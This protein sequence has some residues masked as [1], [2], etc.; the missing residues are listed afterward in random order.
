MSARLFLFLILANFSTS[1]AIRKSD[2]V[3]EFCANI[4]KAKQASNYG[5]FNKSYQWLL[6]DSENI[7][8]INFKNAT[9]GIGLNAQVTYGNTSSVEMFSLYDLHSKG[10][11]LKAPLIANE[12]ARWSENKG[13]AVDF[14]MEFVQGVQN[15]RNFHGQNLRG[16]VVIDRDDIEPTQAND[17]LSTP[18][19][20]VGVTAFSKYH[21]NLVKI[22]QQFYNFSVNYRITHGW[23]GRLPGSQFRLGLLGVVQRNEADVAASGMFNRINRLPEFDTIHES[24]KLELAFLYRMTGELKDGQKSGGS[25]LL[26]FDD[27]VWIV[28]CVFVALMGLAWKIIVFLEKYHCRLEKRC[29]VVVNA[30]S[31]VCQQGL[32]QTPERTSTRI[33]SF[34][35][36]L[37]SMIMYNF[38]TSSVVGGL[39]STRVK[40]PQNL[41][42]LAASPLILSFE[43]VGYNK[44]VFR[45]ANSS[46]LKHIYHTRVEPYR[47]PSMLPAY[48]T[49]KDAVPYI[50]TG[51]YA[52]H[53]EVMDAYPEIAKVFDPNEICDLR[54]LP[55][56]FDVQLIAMVVTKR[57]TYTEMFRI[58]LHRARELG[59]I[60]R[61]LRA[62]RPEKP[63]CQSG[64]T[65]HPVTLNGVMNAFFILEVGILTSAA[66]LLVE[67]LLKRI[68]PDEF[69]VWNLSRT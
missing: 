42:E 12:Y 27:N 69:L 49:V 6:V 21:Y 60:S 37:F 52:F 45:E 46:L 62:H 48:T 65:V 4:V 1:M 50:Q 20:L 43:D 13:F 10:Q 64:S 36:L 67:L 58:A 63:R 40:G 39:L 28:S 29:N 47:P 2:L 24:W 34:A 25:F 18:S 51:R 14:P 26:P 30:L 44:I 66:L 17:I 55:A 31:I 16:V 9:H 22:L 54:S 19:K 23:A 56:F 7:G 57:S 8:L 11:H 3:M 38:Y 41:S 59:L 61:E 5:Y 33:I 32:N 53:C 35:F 68:I 15:R